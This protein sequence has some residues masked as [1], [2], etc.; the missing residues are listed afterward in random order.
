M[1]RQYRQAIDRCLELAP[2]LLRVVLGGSTPQPGSPPD[3]NGAA[4]LPMRSVG[5]T[6]GESD[7]F[8]DS[9]PEV[10]VFPELA[11]KLASI[12]HTA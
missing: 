5:V 8:A 6:V 11:S 12:Q 2:S 7:G 4:G 3:P 1:V 10:E 9:E